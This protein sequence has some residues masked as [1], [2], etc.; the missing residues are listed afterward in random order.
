MKITYYIALILA[1]TVSTPI[2]FAQTPTVAEDTTPTTTVVPTK[3]TD[4]DV[5]KLKEKVA[6]TVLG[7]N[8]TA[9]VTAGTI[10]TIK[11]DVV[12]LETKDDDVQVTLDDALT[13]YFEI[14]GTITKEI[15]KDGI[16]KSDYIFVSGPEINGSITANTVYKDQ[17]Y[18]SFVGKITEANS[19]DFTVKIVTL[20]KSNYTL[21]V[22]TRT[23]QELLNIKT[24]EPEKIGFSKLKEGDSIHVFVKANLENPKTT[25]FDAERILVI[26]NEYFM[27]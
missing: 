24:L 14:Q 16:Q 27:Q 3:V 20:D 15:K 9:T 25:R 7:M 18:I 26:P 8:E 23:T 10:T 11:G 1:L 13:E 21:D 5:D 4:E 19:T 22:Q 17:P 12:T 2:V 6:K